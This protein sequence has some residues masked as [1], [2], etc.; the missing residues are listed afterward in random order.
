MAPRFSVLL[1][2]H[3]RADVVGYAIESVLAQTEPSFELLV[4]G[5][6]CT[7]ETAAV[8]GAFDDERIRWFDLPKAPGFGYANRNLGL[9]EAR[10]ELIAFL[11]H[12]DLLLPD[13]LEQ[14]GPVFDDPAIEWAYSRPLWMD[15]EGVAVPFAV[16]LRRPDALKAFLEVDNAVPAVCVVHRRSCLDRYGDWPEDVERGGDWELWRRIVGP[17]GGTNLAYVPAVTSIHFRARWR[18]QSGWGPQ[19]LSD[20]LEAAH[21][22]WWPRELRVEVPGDALPQAAVWQTL[23]GDGRG[24]TH[25]LRVGVVEVIDGFAWS[26][27]GLRWNWMHEAGRADRLQAQLDEQA[28][29]TDGIRQRLVA[30]QALNQEMI[31]STSWRTTRPARRLGRAVR[32]R[33]RGA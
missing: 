29:E 17:S 3:Q 20:W 31:G 21:D 16:D 9:R 30:Q 7:D 28:L 25:R 22:G 4:V 6:G 19:P 5:D 23:S 11:A 26:A 13:H 1:P 10:G 2:T 8:V 15:D 33:L 27:Q 24:F 12:D 14:L 32:R 18:G